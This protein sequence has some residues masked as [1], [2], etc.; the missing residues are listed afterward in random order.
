MA[1]LALAAVLLGAPYFDALVALSCG[2]LAWE[3]RRLCGGGRF[4]A[5]G[6]LLLGGVLA[7]VGAAAVGQFMAAG[8]LALCAAAAV[9]GALARRGSASALWH[10]A[11]VLYL[12][13]PSVALLWLQARAG[14]GAVLWLFLVV[15]ATDIA[16]Y[17]VG[18]G[19]GGP[20]LAPRFS[21]RK[22]WAGLGGGV[23]AAAATGALLAPALGIS[24]RAILGA[25]SALISLV[26]QGGDL[27]E[28]AI[29]RRFQIKDMSG[30]IP[31]HGGLFDRVDGLLAA[32]PAVALIELFSAGGAL[33][34]R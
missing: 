20:R 33:S 3:W 14:S 34:W 26:A 28:S 32:A 31:G 30:L 2:V 8:V 21:P 17:A 23:L 27:A 15:W 12:A 4:G 10:A 7:V 1:P 11:G 24:S 13:V 9:Y 22:T 18:R 29:K 19:L 16:A 6:W 25:L 5:V